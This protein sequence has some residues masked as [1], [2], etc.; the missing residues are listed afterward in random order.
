MSH[1][2][3]DLDGPW[4]AI[5]ALDR[6]EMAVW[7]RGATPV[8]VKG[9]M[10]ESR[11]GRRYLVPGEDGRTLVAVARHHEPTLF[12]PLDIGRWPDPLP[13]PAILQ[14]A[15]PPLRPPAE[16]AKA[17][18]A[19]A[20]SP[21]L[22]EAIAYS[23][24]GR[25]DI[26][27]CEARLIRALKTDRALPDTD[28][29]KLAVRSQWPETAYAPGDWPPEITT[30]WTPFPEDVRDY[31]IAMAWFVRLNGFDR[32]LL[33]QRAR[34]YSFGR[35]AEENGGRSDEWARQ[36]YLGALTRGLYAANLAGGGA[37]AAGPRPVAASGRR[38][39]RAA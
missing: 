29:A 11:R 2:L 10:R 24:P 26:E 23:P 21:P 3:P 13:A 33:R 22:P 14:P 37:D 20:G 35:M 19:P 39:R 9:V 16:R 8:P 34:G 6:A 18:L 12:Q 17:R 4:F 32:R 36:Q 5:G 38:P 30:R 28:K 7:L 1:L 25:I 27:E 15:P 31:L